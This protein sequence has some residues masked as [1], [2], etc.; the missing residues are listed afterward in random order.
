M[1]SLKKEVRTAISLV[2]AGKKSG[3]LWLNMLREASGCRTDFVILRE[4]KGPQQE[5]EVHSLADD[6][7]LSTGAVKPPI[8]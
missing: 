7:S 6:D 5:L 3:Y 8:R 2:R 4:Q 1:R